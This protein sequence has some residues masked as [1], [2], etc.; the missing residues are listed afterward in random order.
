MTRRTFHDDSLREWEVYVSGGQPETE[1]AARIYFLC[2][3]EPRERA[4]F[5]AHDSRD[6]A[7]AEGELRRLDDSDLL[8]M[9]Q[10]AEPLD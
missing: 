1:A 6:V 4:R 9:L 2:L 8:E 3:T 5:V 7:E 10:E